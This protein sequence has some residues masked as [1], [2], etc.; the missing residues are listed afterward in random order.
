M[1]IF[2]S[3]VFLQQSCSFGLVS[4]VYP[5]RREQITMIIP[6]LALL[7]LMIPR[8]F[9]LDWLCNRGLVLH[10]LKKK[11][12]GARTGDSVLKLLP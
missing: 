11:K 8:G 12:L 2:W 5:A 4:N 9:K 10:K 1:L 3:G 7:K 6:H